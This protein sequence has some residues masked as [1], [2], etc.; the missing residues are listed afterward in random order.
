MILDIESDQGTSTESN[1]GMT[2]YLTTFGELEPK[3][4]SLVS[5]ALADKAFAHSL[6]FVDTTTLVTDEDPAAYVSNTDSWY[7]SKVF[8]GIVI[9]IGA[10]TKSTTSYS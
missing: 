7:L 9:D 4:A 6:I 2:T 3:E 5:N 8:Q 1:K 10:S